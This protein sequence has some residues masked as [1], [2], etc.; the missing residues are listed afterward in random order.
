MRG[1][2][3]FAGQRCV[4]DGLETAWHAPA[5]PR[6]SLK[7]LLPSADH[8]IH[9]CK[10]HNMVHLFKGRVSCQMESRTLLCEVKSF[11]F[12]ECV[13]CSDARFQTRSP[14][15]LRR[16]S[17]GL[18]RCQGAAMPTSLTPSLFCTDNGAMIAYAGCQRLLAQQ[19]SDLAITVSSRWNLEALDAIDNTVT[20][21]G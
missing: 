10:C 8:S 9:V 18:R 5:F 7:D 6:A 1:F 3:C 19:Q 15:C 4:V 16:L 2:A 21:N 14:G 13:L 12:D 17:G 11:N 20:S